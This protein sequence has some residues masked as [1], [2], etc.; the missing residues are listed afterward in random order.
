MSGV[1]NDYLVTHIKCHGH[2]SVYP[3]SVNNI[4]HA[5]KIHIILPVK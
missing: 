5:S 4:L 3:V 2:A 1:G